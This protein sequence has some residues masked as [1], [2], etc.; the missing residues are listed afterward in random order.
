MEDADLLIRIAAGD[1]AAL[2]LLYDRY[3]TLVHSLALRILSDRAAAEDVTQEV[4]LKVW[5]FGARFNEERGRV[6]T[7][8]LNITRNT[9]IDLLRA[10]RRA[11]PDRFEPLENAA[12]LGD[13]GPS[14]EAL[15]EVSVLGAQVR[16]ALLRLAPEQRQ[17]IDLAYFQGKTQQQIAEETRVPLGT[18]KSRARLALDNLRST[19]LAPHRREVE[20]LGWRG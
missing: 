18:V 9:A 2:H 16:E 7:W 3:G 10:G 14:T 20:H 19:L 13:R 11:S 8:L 5:R 6:S 15:V 12:D 17:V 1:A 4:F